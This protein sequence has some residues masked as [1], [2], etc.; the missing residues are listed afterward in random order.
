[1]LK[2]IF[3]VVKNIIIYENEPHIKTVY[4]S[5]LRSRLAGIRFE[6]PNPL[7]GFNED[8]KL[9][10]GDNIQTMIDCMSL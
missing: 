6:P 4:I 2:D 5:I 7:Q 8:K 1:M 9:D 3:I 10:T